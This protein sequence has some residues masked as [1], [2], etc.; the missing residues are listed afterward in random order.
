MV[1]DDLEFLIER[2]ISKIGNALLNTRSEDL[3]KYDLTPVQSETL[4][5]YAAAPG[6]SILDLKEHLDISHQAA[7]NLIERSKLKRLVYAKTSSEDARYKKIYLTEQGERIYGESTLL[8]HHVGQDLLQ[9]ISDAEKKELLRLL[10]KINE[11]V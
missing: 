3:K 10:L 6:A 4:L 5:F 8:G 11:N 2:K 9:G 1:L 7:R